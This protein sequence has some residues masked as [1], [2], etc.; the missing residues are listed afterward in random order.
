VQ[1][2]THTQL[3]FLNMAFVVLIY[4]LSHTRKN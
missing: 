2:A 3:T 1:V 4:D